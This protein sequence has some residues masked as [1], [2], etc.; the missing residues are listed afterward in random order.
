MFG[1]A[2]PYFLLLIPLAFLLIYFDLSLAREPA[3]YV[4]VPEGLIAQTQ[5]GG[6]SGLQMLRPLYLLLGAW[7][8]MI[9]ALSGP[10]QTLPELAAKVTGHEIVLAIDL[11]GSMVQRDFTLDGKTVTRIDAVKSVAQ[12]FIRNRAGDRL[13]LIFFGSTAYFATPQTYDIEAVA[14]ALEQAEIGISGRATGIG[15]AMGLALK[16]LDTSDST[17]KTVILLSDGVNNAGPV[18]PRD[19]A[20]LARDKGVLFHTIALGPL[21]VGETDLK[22][23][24]VDEGTLKAIASTTNGVFFRVRVTEDLKEVMQEID[25]LETRE[26]DGPGADIY[27]DLWIWPAILSLLLLVCALMWQDRRES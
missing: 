5:T 9:I 23:G 13:S 27:R 24:V 3:S 12:S 16:R 19:A 7:V 17:S 21:A 15:D 14:H 18:R 4:F 6:L 11:S 20:K 2:D 25:R 26:R 10:R 1:F 8:V 22:R